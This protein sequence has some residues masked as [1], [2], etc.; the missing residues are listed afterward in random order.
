MNKSN[1]YQILEW[2]AH[3][4]GLLPLLVVFAIAFVTLTGGTTTLG[5]VSATTFLADAAMIAFALMLAMTPIT[6]FTGW[7]W[8]QVLKKPFGLYAYA[9]SAIHFLM[10]SSS[11]GFDPFGIS[12]GVFSN[13]MLATGGIALFAMIPLAIT[14]NRWSMRLLGRNWKRLHML[15]YGIAIL[16]IAHLFF[17]GQALPWA[18]L[19]TV[20]LIV[21]LPPVRQAIVSWR[22]GRSNSQT[23]AAA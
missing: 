22:T 2:A 4:I 9:Y 19:F 8:P 6:I 5:F 14:S 7:R 10:F 13:A 12:A 15:V 23:P 17:L 1:N 11:F 20:L 18:I 16:L 21:R 3:A